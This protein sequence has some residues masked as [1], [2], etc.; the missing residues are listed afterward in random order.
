MKDKKKI[1]IGL[2]SIVILASLI[3]IIVFI[4]NKKN[5]NNLEKKLSDMVV[6]YYEQEFVKIQPNFLKQWGEYTVDLD[7]LKGFNRDV[8]VFEEHNCDMTDT[9]VKLTYKDDSSYDIDVHLACEEK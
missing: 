1:I 3:F 6:E 9:Y 8:S 4:V 7:N 5:D 2:V